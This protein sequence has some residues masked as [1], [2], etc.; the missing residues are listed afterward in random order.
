MVPNK[1][2]KT[3]FETVA[4]P[5]ATRKKMGVMAMKVFCAGG[6]DVRASAEKL[7]Y[8]TLSL[9]VTTAVVG[10]PKLEHISETCSLLKQPGRFPNRKCGI[11]RNGYRR[12]I[13]LPSIDFSAVTWTRN[14]G[15]V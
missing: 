13:R 10:M 4:L 2:M 6:P 11:C 12:R 1:A 3:S 5:V 7:L 8:Y 9:P 15:E 14:K